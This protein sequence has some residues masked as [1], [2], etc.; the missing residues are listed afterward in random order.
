VVQVLDRMM[1]GLYTYD[2]HGQYG[3]LTTENTVEVYE[4]SWGLQPDFVGK[5]VPKTIHWVEQVRGHAFA[6]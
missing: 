1:C 3:F 4:Q 2:L 5:D 6:S